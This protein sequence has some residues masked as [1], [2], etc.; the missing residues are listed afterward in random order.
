[1][2]ETNNWAKEASDSLRDLADK[3]AQAPVPELLGQKYIAFQRLR[4]DA[5]TAILSLT[6]S[7]DFD[8][9]IYL[10]ELDEKADRAD[11]QVAFDKAKSEKA[12]NGLS[13]PSNNRVSGSCMLYVGSSFRTGLRRATLAS[14]LTQHLLSAP[15][16]TYALNLSH[17][18]TGLS[19]GIIIRAFQYPDA[20]DRGV[21]VAIED[22]LSANLKPMFGR[23]GTQR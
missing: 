7:I 15:K 23:R 8:R 14:R 11:V 18:A 5:A 1:V 3:V 10:I 22:N 4:E 12:A 13:L 2:I 17:W 6:A 20:V 21:V 16:G 19:G 9:C